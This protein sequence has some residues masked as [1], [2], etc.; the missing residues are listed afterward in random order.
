[1]QEVSNKNV[2]NC[3]GVLQS[4]WGIIQNPSR[5]WNLNTIKDIPMTCVIIHNMIIEDEQDQELEPIITQ[6]NHVPWRRGLSSEHY[7]R[8]MK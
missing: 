6:P 3:F 7:V 2:E 8:D 5:Q 4:N 1:M